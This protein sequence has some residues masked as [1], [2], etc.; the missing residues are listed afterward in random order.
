MAATTSTASAA[1]SNNKPLF[2]TIETARSDL[3]QH[4]LARVLNSATHSAATPKNTASAD[5][6][7]T[8]SQNEALASSVAISR[9]MAHHA[10]ADRFQAWV[11]SAS[12]LLHFVTK[13]RAIWKWLRR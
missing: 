9:I 7:L 11:L 10:S 3:S 5:Q 13:V 6:A 4:H 2:D 8:E 12:A 1:V